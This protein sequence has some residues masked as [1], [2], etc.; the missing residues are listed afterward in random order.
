MSNELDESF[1]NLITSSLHVAAMKS[2]PLP[3]AEY[4][5]QMYLALKEMLNDNEL[6]LKEVSKI[7][8][9]MLTAM[10]DDTDIHNYLVD[11]REEITFLKNEFRS[12]EGVN[13][14]L[15]S[16][17]SDPTPLE[18]ARERVRFFLKKYDDAA[19]TDKLS[20]V[21]QFIEDSKFFVEDCLRENGMNSQEF[22]DVSDN[23]FMIPVSKVNELLEQFKY[24][25]IKR[26]KIFESKVNVGFGNSVWE[27]Y[28]YLLLNYSKWPLTVDAKTLWSMWILQFGQLKISERSNQNEGCFIATACYGSYDD[29]NVLV[30]RNFRDEYLANKVFGRMFIKTYYFFSPQLA[31]FISKSNGL[32]AI[33]RFFLV[34]PIV[35]FVSK[36]Y[37]K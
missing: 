27:E 26:R 7:P 15:S 1:K 14:F 21:I 6:V 25:S 34:Q 11:Y 5:F 30:L 31:R 4:I 13:A 9:A 2:P 8:G 12:L 22:K 35:R 17:H 29:S 32:S 3:T 20:V 24:D 28:S 33:T 19:L 10:D 23:I 37:F 18:N 16:F 36:K